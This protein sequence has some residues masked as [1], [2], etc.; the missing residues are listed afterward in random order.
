MLR[1]LVGQ[2]EDRVELPIEIDE[3]RT[4]IINF[5]IQDRIIFSAE[6]LDTGVLKGAYYQWRESPI[7]YGESTW[8][9]LIVYP[10]G[11]DLPWQRVICAKELIHLCDQQVV[12]ART[13][14]AVEGLAR[15]LV[16]PFEGASSDLLDILA[17]TDKLA[18]Y[19]SLNLL[20]P[21]AA[22]K[23]AREKIKKHE[24]TEAAVADW[25]VLPL[26]HVMLMLDDSWDRLS[27]LLI[28]IG[29]GDHF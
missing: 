20:F 23:L 19:Q 25:A 10:Q 18:Q 8:T 1:K 9:S 4:A 16:G 6:D 5:G 22:R 11:V 12:R 24:I 3:L 21:V 27:E 13:P 29:N 26:E 7:P 28:A 15:K 14:N 2:F 17:S